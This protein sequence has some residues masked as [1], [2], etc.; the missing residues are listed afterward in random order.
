MI[1]RPPHGLANEEVLRKNDPRQVSQVE[2]SQKYLPDYPLFKVI[3]MIYQETGRGG[4]AGK[5]SQPSSTP[6]PS[7]SPG[8]VP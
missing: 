5:H 8:H 3:N 4:L 6:S 7:A 2:F 1:E